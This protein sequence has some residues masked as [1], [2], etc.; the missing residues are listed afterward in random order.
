MKSKQAVRLLPILVNFGFIAA[1]LT[2]C[3]PIGS[4][5]PLDQDAFATEAAPVVPVDNFR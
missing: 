1:A 2:A 5:D 3:Q 4:G